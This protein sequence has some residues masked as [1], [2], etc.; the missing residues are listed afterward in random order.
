[1]SKHDKKLNKHYKNKS[2]TFKLAYDAILVCLVCIALVSAYKIFT[3][4]SGYMSSQNAYQGIRKEVA[5]EGFTGNIDWSKLRKINEDVVGWI[6]LKD[7][8]I[9]Y[10]IVNSHD[11]KEYLTTLFDK[12]YGVSGTIFVDCDTQFP[13]D[14]FST[15]VYGHHMKDGSMFNNIKKFKDRDYANSHSRFEL[16]TPDAKYHLD[17]AAFLNCPYDCYVYTP[18]IADDERD[19]FFK[20]VNVLAD[21]RTDVKLTKN[22]KIVVLSTCAYEYDGARYVIIGKLTPWS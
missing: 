10:P 3:I 12:T 11:N 15:V 5:E 21:Y 20:T 17:V 18:N 1:M 13:F 7:S 8:N 19:K 22:D 2:K 6:Y 14:Q 16:I 9:D 4:V